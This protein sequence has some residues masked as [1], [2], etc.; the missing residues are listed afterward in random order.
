MSRLV[1]YLTIAAVVAAAAEGF[2]RVPLQRVRRPNGDRRQI[3]ARNGDEVPLSD[4]QYVA[5]I[6]LGTP[7]QPIRV[8]LDTGSSDLWVPS[9]ELC[10]SG[11][12]CNLHHV[13]Y[14]TKSKSFQ[15]EDQPFSIQ[16]GSG[17]VQ[18]VC[19]S[20]VLQIPGLSP[21]KITFG[22]VTG[23]GEGIL[24]D[25][26][27]DGILGLS[28]L[29]RSTISPSGDLTNCI[30]QPLFS[31]Y[32][33]QDGGEVIFGGMDSK[34]YHGD[35]TYVPLLSTSL[36]PV[37]VP[38]LSIGDQTITNDVGIAIVDTGTTSLVVSPEAYYLI[39]SIM[40]DYQCGEG[41][42]NLTFLINNIP[43]PLESKFLFDENC[44]LQVTAADQTW[45]LG[46]PFLRQY[47]SVFDMGNKQVGFAPAVQA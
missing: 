31:F 41:A 13:F 45:I 35:I 44:N 30:N 40:Q 27:T 24:F 29:Y 5:T 11:Y 46:L 23:E 10:D 38:S 3:S 15:Q 47:Y 32:I 18:G 6:E 25:N 2:L 21:M 20:D 33:G 4:P 39:S 37:S 36:F 12:D 19:S 22:L 14:P 9:S 17:P 16:Y 8:V 7:G 28:Y 34:Y 42:P 26:T 43:F 1:V